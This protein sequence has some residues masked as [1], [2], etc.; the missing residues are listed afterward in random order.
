MCQGTSEITLLPFTVFSSSLFLFHQRHFDIKSTGV[1][2]MMKS[3][4]IVHAQ[5]TG[6]DTKDLCLYFLKHSCFFH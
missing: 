5:L 1:I 6:T 2:K 3:S 4:I